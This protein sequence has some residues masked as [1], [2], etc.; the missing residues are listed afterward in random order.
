[1]IKK[2]CI[3][4]ILKKQFYE[5]INTWERINIYLEQNIATCTLN[6]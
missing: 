3:A 4:W 5:A 2:N 1:M 6:I